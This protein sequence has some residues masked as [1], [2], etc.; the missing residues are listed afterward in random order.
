[1]TWAVVAAHILHCII[2]FGCIAVK[3]I[4]GGLEDRS[5]SSTP[6]L[7]LLTRMDSLSFDPPFPMRDRHPCTRSASVRQEAVRTKHARHNHATFSFDSNGPRP[8]KR[9]H[10]CC[11]QA[12]TRRARR[13]SSIPCQV[14]LRGGLKVQSFKQTQIR[15]YADLAANWVGTLVGT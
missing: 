7:L 3:Y 12:M 2:A 6:K 13:T 9:S 5:Y 8:F 1:M 4:C 10:L 15:Q 14:S 11:A